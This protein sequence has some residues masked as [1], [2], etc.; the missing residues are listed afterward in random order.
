MKLVKIGLVATAV[1]AAIAFVGVGRPDFARGSAP[2]GRTVTV[3][4][5]GSVESVPNQAGL[6]VGVSSDAVSAQAAL[7]ANADKSA[8]VIEAIRTAGVAKPDLQTTDVSVSPRW[9]NRGRQDGFTAHS[10]VQVKVASVARAGAIIDAA[11][12]AGATET[13]GPS[14]DRS[15]RS[16]LYRNALKAAFSDARGKAATLAGEAGTSVGAVQRIEESPGVQAMP[17]FSAAKESA[18]PIE[19]GTTEV[20]ATV[21]VTFSLS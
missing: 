21:T 16:E 3:T 2:P 15:D 14:F 18:T 6:S 7:A 10:S 9:D 19:P 4:G 1:A 13:S 5:T 12:A 8:N 20:Q 17:L 11:I